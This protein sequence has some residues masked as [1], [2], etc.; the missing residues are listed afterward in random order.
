[1]YAT[2]TA[3]PHNAF[4]LATPQRRGGL[5]RRL[6]GRGHVVVAQAH[7]AHHAAQWTHAFERIGARHFCHVHVQQARSQSWAV[8]R[9]RLRD[10]NLADQTLAR[11]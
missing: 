8:G 10:G 11:T 1:M 4:A 3:D 7:T 6:G 2:L 9:Q 5:G